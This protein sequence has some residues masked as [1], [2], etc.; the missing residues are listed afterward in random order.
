MLESYHEGIEE[1]PSDKR[2]ENEKYERKRTFV[3]QLKSIKP[4]SSKFGRNLDVIKYR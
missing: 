2:I 3:S 1:F 4:K